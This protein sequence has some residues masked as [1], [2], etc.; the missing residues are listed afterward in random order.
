[1]KTL[2]PLVLS[3][4]ALLLLT[5]SQ[6]VRLKLVDPSAPPTLIPSKEKIMKNGK[7]SIPIIYIVGR[8]RITAQPNRLYI[9]S[10]LG[11]NLPCIPPLG[12]ATI[13]VLTNYVQAF[14]TTYLV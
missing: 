2:F 10:E 6:V 5:M 12:Y 3:N 9:I 8:R 7:L 14:D 13:Y 11:E 1:M 4:F